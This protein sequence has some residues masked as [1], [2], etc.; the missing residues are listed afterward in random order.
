MITNFY[1]RIQNPVL[2][3]TEMTFDPPLIFETYPN[4]LNNLYLGQQL[5]VVGRYDEN[6]SVTAIFEGETFGQPQTYTYGLNLS[7][8]IVEGNSFLIKIWAKKK[9]DHL[10][11]EYFNYDPTSPEAE[12][13]KEE[14]ID[15]SI[16][17]NVMSPFTS[18]SGGGITGLEFDEIVDGGTTESLTYNFPNPF[19]RQTEIF[20]MIQEDYY[21]V[22]EVNIY[23][24]FGRK[25]MTL[26][27]NVTGA[28]K[29]CVVW[30]GA[31]ANG[32]ELPL[33]HYFYN[34]SFGTTKQ[35]G[36]MVKY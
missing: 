5:I 3:N 31:N 18:L 33:G 36:R 7:D 22:V 19:K 9:I 8:S 30:N 35:N 13:I 24:L 28:G 16:C 34:V 6:D 11:V 29:Y 14:I 10:F 27:A 17:Y 23:D 12:E 4:P 25:L 15:I 32:L 2:L 20:F 21:G 1:L 26:S